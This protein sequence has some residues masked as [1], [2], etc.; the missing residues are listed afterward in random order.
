MSRNF[1][2]IAAEALQLPEPEQ[3]RLARTLLENSEANGNTE[4]DAAWEEEIERRIRL[5][6]SGIAKGRSYKE[7]LVATDRRLN[8]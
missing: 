1:A 4:V 5:I 3:L 6:D 7:V 2:I 8:K